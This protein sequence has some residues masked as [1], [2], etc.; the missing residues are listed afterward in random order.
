[1]ATLTGNGLKYLRVNAGETAVEYATVSGSG[2][3]VGPASATDN[4]ITRF[5][6]T[7]GKLVQN[8]G[9][10]IDDTNNITGIGTLDIGNADTTISRSAAGI[11]AVEGVAVP[12]ISS[13]DTLSNKTLTAPKF[14]DLGFIADANGNEMLIFDTVASAVNEITIANAAT[15]GT[16][17][18]SAT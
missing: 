13:T 8:S 3:V 16:P 11:I 14:A 4:A 2:D 10:I 12:T 1:M 9:V 7:T 5:D 18:I 6:G 17:T 15:T